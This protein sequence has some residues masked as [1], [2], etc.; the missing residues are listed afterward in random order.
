MLQQINLTIVQQVG[1]IVYI[2]TRLHKLCTAIRLLNIINN[3]QI[4]FNDYLK[5]VVYSC[6]STKKT[7]KIK[8][9]NTKIVILQF[10]V[11]VLILAT[12]SYQL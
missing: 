10:T 8:I 1:P 9:Y 12:F 4:L 6:L 3:I 7:T 5:P 11:F 2:I